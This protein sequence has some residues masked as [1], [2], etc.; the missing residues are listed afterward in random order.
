MS[1]V[2]GWIPSIIDD[3]CRAPESGSYLV[4]NLTS[5]LT[6]YKSHVG[7]TRASK[8][9]LESEGHK[10]FAPLPF[11]KVYAKLLEAFRGLFT[12]KDKS[13]SELDDVLKNAWPGM[14]SA[15][16]DVLSAEEEGRYVPQT[17]DSAE[18]EDRRGLR[19][20]IVQTMSTL[21]L[22]IR[23]HTPTA[24]DPQ[25][26]VLWAASRMFDG[27]HSSTECLFSLLEMVQECK[28]SAA[29]QATLF[30]DNPLAATVFC[31]G[32]GS[33][34]SQLRTQ[35]LRTIAA[36][37]ETWLDG[38]L[39]DRFLEAGLVPLLAKCVRVEESWSIVA[40]YLSTVI[41]KL[42]GLMDGE[43]NTME[44]FVQE[45]NEAH[46]HGRYRL[47]GAVLYLWYQPPQAGVAEDVLVSLVHHVV[48]DHLDLIE[49]GKMVN[50]DQHT[51]AYHALAGDIPMAGR[52]FLEELKP[53]APA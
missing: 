23:G 19:R 17:G 43:R 22:H 42:G 38:G 28:A 51:R 4:A 1:R 39:A 52:A 40:P 35:T 8:D 24:Q 33:A 44:G 12:Q 20:E 27:P 50:E 31:S 37:A 26:A 3:P 7:M 9:Y 49:P 45:I 6:V 11:L 25:A 21:Y 34:S 18:L 32:L 48:M 13:V 47:A 2:G 53:L 46:A 36:Q 10:G 30:Q 29:V 14:L 15:L 16:V 5:A 41:S